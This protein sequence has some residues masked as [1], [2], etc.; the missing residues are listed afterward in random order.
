MDTDEVRERLAMAVGDTLRIGDVLG[1]GAFAMV[2]RAHDP[3]LQRD[4]AVKVINPEL[5]LSEELEEQFLREASA[6]GRRAL[7]GSR[8]R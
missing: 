6:A 7:G 2:F 4:V 3:F 1:T 8:R 5:G